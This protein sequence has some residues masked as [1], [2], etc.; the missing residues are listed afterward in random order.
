MG[1]GY[2]GFLLYPGFP[3]KIG[4]MRI[5]RPNICSF[6]VALFVLLAAAPA[7][8]GDDGLFVLVTETVAQG[9]PATKYWWREGATPQWTP[10]DLA[11]RDALER[12]G[13]GFRAVPNTSTL[14][15]IYRTAAPS[16]SNA[17][18]MATV[19]GMASP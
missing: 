13:A 14:S 4:A 1:I 9:E 8:A 10:T 6:A 11:L 15:K 2:T 5:P 7:F 12:S 19:F 17:T 3:P 16:D 18:A